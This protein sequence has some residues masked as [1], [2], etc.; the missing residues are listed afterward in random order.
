MNHHVC[1][2]WKWHCH[3][4]YTGIPPPISRVKRKQSHSGSWGQS[5]TK[6]RRLWQSPRQTPRRRLSGGCSG[7]WW[8]M[9]HGIHGASWRCWL[10]TMALMVIFYGPVI[11]DHISRSIG[12]SIWINLGWNASLMHHRSPSKNELAGAGEA[13]GLWT[14]EVETDVDGTQANPAT[15]PV[16]MPW[17]CG[18]GN[19]QRVGSWGCET[20]NRNEPYYHPL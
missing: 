19:Q 3:W 12:N 20:W 2:P 15:R 14:A 6:K 18:S 13:R 1:S 16:R 4:G 17:T 8:I 5:L 11:L 9:L 7:C 10:K